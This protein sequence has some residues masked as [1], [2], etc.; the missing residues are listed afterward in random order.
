[1]SVQ[2]L[3]RS[4]PDPARSTAAVGEGLDRAT[5]GRALLLAAGGFIALLDGTVVGVATPTIAG[6]FGAAIA[7]VQWASTGYLLAMATVIPFTGWAAQRFGARQAWLASLAT[8]LV[9]SVASGLAWSLGTLIAFRAVQG[10]GAGMLFPLMRILAVQIAG[11]ERMGRVMAL[12]AIPVQMAPIIGPLLGGAV[13]SD[14]SWRWAF[15]INVPILLL[16]IAGSWRFL[17]NE[18][19]GATSAL[20]PIGIVTLGTGIAATLYALSEMSTPGNRHPVWPIAVVAIVLL[21][22]HV[23]RARA[24]DRITGLDFDLFRHRAFS[25]SAMVSFLN[26]ASMYAV[27]FL[28][29]LLVQRFSGKSALQAGLTLAPQGLGMLI[30]VLAVGRLV[31]LRSSP[32]RLV[33]IGLLVVA[34]GTIPIAVLDPA[35]HGVVLFLALFVRGVGLAYAVGPTMLTLYHGLPAERFAGAT[36]SNAIVQQLGGAVGVAA[37]ALLLDGLG[38]S[39]PGLGTYR[40]ILWITT[41]VVAVTAVAAAALPSRGGG[42]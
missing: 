20:D 37:V 30:A 35:T 1:M 9:G 26:N 41:A 33:L 8:F 23:L 27:I 19:A 6:N 4:N 38:G 29:P 18:P 11:R 36:T 25:A 5:A 40:A 34:I 24:T 7:N 22:A 15:F 32:R 42:S 3:R 39:D 2:S 14:L 21:A 13:V 28:I 10:L 12:T 16:A 17:P 31:D